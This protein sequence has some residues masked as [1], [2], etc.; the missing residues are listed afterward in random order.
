MI[1]DDIKQALVDSMKAGDTARRDTIRLI[2]A[3]LK[4][5]DIELRGSANA[6][7]DDVLVTEVLQ[8]MVKQR[9]ESIELYEKGGR[10]ELAAA[11]SAEVAVI[12]SFLPAQMD[13]AQIAAAVDAIVTETG[14]GSVKDMGRVMAVLKERHAG[15]LDMSKASAAVKAR[16]SS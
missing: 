15:Q 13:D 1:R 11:E 9:R 6:P 12:E 5:R 2:Q 3:A 16:L 14:A 7:E 8:K 10:A 4:N